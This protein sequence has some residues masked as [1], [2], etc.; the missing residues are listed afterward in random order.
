M[1][2]DWGWGGWEG[3]PALSYLP[4]GTES[5]KGAPS[6]PLPHRSPILGE[7]DMAF[8]RVSSPLPLGVEAKREGRAQGTVCD[9][10]ADRL[11]CPPQHTHAPQP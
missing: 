6:T 9:G 2:G 4:Q 3:S 1:E 10:R 8:P 5:W 7:R 11:F